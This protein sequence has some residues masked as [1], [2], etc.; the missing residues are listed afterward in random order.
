MHTSLDGFVAG[1]GGE[2]DWISVNEEIFDY[3]GHE[4]DKA[5]IALY[6]RVTFEMMDS[7]WPTAADKPHASRHDIRHSTWYN[8]VPKVILS[9][10]W[11]DRHLPNTTIISRNLK[12]EI[13]KQKRRTERNIIMFGS[14]S[15]AHAL[16]AEELIDEFWLFINPVLLGRGIPLFR[17]IRQ[18]QKL[19]LLDCRS[20]SSGVTCLHYDRVPSSGA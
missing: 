13:N 8:Q 18:Q 12:E 10:S 16:M 17:D 3:A 15:A 1:T 11:K 6:G 20:F 19:R 2:M 4:T 14:P 9:E 7:Y 5:D